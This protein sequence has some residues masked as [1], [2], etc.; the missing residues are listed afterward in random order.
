MVLWSQAELGLNKAPL[1][2][3]HWTNHLDLAIAS[4]SS[5]EQWGLL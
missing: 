4:V 3:Q 2:L 5:S 1:P